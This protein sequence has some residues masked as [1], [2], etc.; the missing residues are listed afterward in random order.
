MYLRRNK[1]RWFMTKYHSPMYTENVTKN[2]NKKEG[3]K[4]KETDTG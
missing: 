2:K 1:I 4:Q 3:R